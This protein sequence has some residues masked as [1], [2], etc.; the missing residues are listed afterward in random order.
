MEVLKD[1]ENDVETENANPVTPV[2][3]LNSAGAQA[4]RSAAGLK[5]DSTSTSEKARDNHQHDE[6][7]EGDPSGKSKSTPC[8]VLHARLVE[9]TS[10]LD[11]TR[12]EL[13]EAS[14]RCIALQDS[15]GTAAEHETVKSAF[16][17]CVDEDGVAI[18]NYLHAVTLVNFHQ[19][20]SIHDPFN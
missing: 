6:T 3:D 13:R 17:R 16:Q 2:R 9:A 12:K 4:E 5:L 19:L 7:C 8:D 18:T 11:S 14:L 20:M 10:S 1:A 15:P